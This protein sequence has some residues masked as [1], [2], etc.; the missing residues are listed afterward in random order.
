[1]GVLGVCLVLVA[2]GV[3][4][5]SAKV[6]QAAGKASENLQKQMTEAAKAHSV[7]VT[8]LSEQIGRMEVQ[9]ARELRDISVEARNKELM[10]MFRVFPKAMEPE[11]YF[12]RLIDSIST[13]LQVDREDAARIMVDISGAKQR[14]TERDV[15]LTDEPEP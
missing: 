4:A 7:L 14:P 6:M 12:H 8:G 1:M 11:E 9:H 13:T 10:A 5:A 2:L 15:G 3:A